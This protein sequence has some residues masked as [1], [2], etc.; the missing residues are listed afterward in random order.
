MDDVATYKQLVQE[1]KA[2]LLE[3]GLNAEVHGKNVPIPR[4]RWYR[5]LA[6]IVQNTRNLAFFVRQELLDGCIGWTDSAEIN[7]KLTDENYN[8][9]LKTDPHARRI[10][11]YVRVKGL[12]PVAE[13][14]WVE[15]KRFLWPAWDNV[16]K[17]ALKSL[18]DDQNVL[19]RTWNGI[20]QYSLFFAHERTIACQLLDTPQLT[21]PEHPH[22]IDINLG[23]GK[24]RKATTV[25]ADNTRS[26]SKT[27]K[28]TQGGN[29]DE[30]EE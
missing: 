2:Y 30:E 24:K 21:R 9:A 4:E 8:N 27:R 6:L 15:R 12:M 7:E 3:H 5:L 28:I 14:E 11:Y 20:A 1:I 17:A 25:V 29:D 26:R 18:N 13:W 22:P 23:Q 19:Q 10:I 16:C